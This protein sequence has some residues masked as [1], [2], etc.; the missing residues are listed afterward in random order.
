[1]GAPPFLF[2][3]VPLFP[4]AL[5]RFFSFF[6]FSPLRKKTWWRPFADA[7]AFP[8][9]FFLCS[10]LLASFVSWTRAKTLLENGLSPP[11]EA[12]PFLEFLRPRE[13]RLK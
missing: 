13:D 5:P 2:E 10:F 6:V 4:P 11:C 12:V 1:M 8:T 3:F 9:G 7:I